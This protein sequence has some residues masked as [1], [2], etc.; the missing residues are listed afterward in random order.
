M[1]FPFILVHLGENHFPDYIKTAIMQIF[2]W[3]PTSTLYFIRSKVHSNK[4][5]INT[6]YNFKEIDLELINESELHV[7]FNKIT[8][9]C[10]QFRNGFWKYTTERLFVLYDFCIQYNIPQFIHIEN[11]NMIYFTSSTVI[12]TIKKYTNGLAY[13]YLGGNEITFGIFFCFNL[14]IFK[15]FLQ[16]IN[17]NNDDK[18]EMIKG[19]D[20]SKVSNDVFILPSGP[21]DTLYDKQYECSKELS[22][23]FD[24]APVGQYLGG[25]DPRNGYSAP[26]HFVNNSSFWKTDNYRYN[27]IYNPLAYYTCNSEKVFVLHIHSKHLCKFVS[28]DIDVCIPYHIKDNNTLKE[29]INSINKYV[30]GI[31]NIYII[32]KDD[33]LI[34]IPNVLWF[35]ENLFSFKLSDIE[36][37]IDKKRCGWY[38]QQF[39]KLFSGQHIPNLS[40]NYLV[41][42]SDVIF[43]KPIFLFDNN[44]ALYNYSNEYSKQYFNIINKFNTKLLKVFPDKS[45]ICHHMLFNTD[46]IK[47]LIPNMN[48]F[49]DFILNN[50]DEDERN[51]SGF[52]EYELYFNYVFTFKYENVKLRKLTFIN[53]TKKI[54]D[55]NIYDYICYPEYLH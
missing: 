19:Y 6:I 42:D 2:L 34:N 45:G 3:N 38:F 25:I 46:Y 52:S 37:Y 9:L 43:Y 35:C 54:S 53:S 31:R 10:T 28:N 11:D 8:V 41:V 23:F 13:P 51:Y 22:G 49:I 44:K 26:F 24:S 18:C 55:P 5:D 36:K 48:N 33:P 7:K 4:L 16:Y 39:I 14:S 20:F 12:P 27:K 47:E 17:D 21:S 29:C 30:I 15:L 40:K 1:S 32:S 50:L